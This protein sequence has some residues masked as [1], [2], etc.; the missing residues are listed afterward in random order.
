[1]NKILRFIL[2][3]GATAFCFFLISVPISMLR[4][5]QNYP[6]LSVVVSLVFSLFVG[7]LIWKQTGSHSNRLIRSMFTGGFLLGSIGFVLGFV[8]PIL[9]TPSSNQGPLLGIFITGPI[10]FILGLIGGGIYGWIKSKQ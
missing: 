4:I 2:T 8:G 3:I 9:L 7:V 6:A 10:G 5:N 1:M